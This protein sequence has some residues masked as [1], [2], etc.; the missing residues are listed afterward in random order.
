M[1]T[2]Q[3]GRKSMKQL[4]LA[5]MACLAAAWA[6]AAGCASTGGGTVKGERFTAF[7]VNLGTAENVRGG[8]AGT[9][10]IVINRWSTEQEREQLLAALA[11]GEDEL[12]KTLQR[13]PPVGTIRTPDRLGWDLHYSHQAPTPDGGRRIFLA[14]DRRISFWE[15][16]NLTRSLNYP[17]TLIEM[18]L[19]KNGHGEGKMSIAARIQA[20][21]DGKW[22]DLENYTTQPVRLQDIRQMR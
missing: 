11:K 19:D 16:V 8:R 13:L 17:F 7:A 5:S 21:P 1:Q 14:T 22:I 4:I 12:L 6:A 18:R 10:E 9:V 15:E 20:S 3:Q 2:S